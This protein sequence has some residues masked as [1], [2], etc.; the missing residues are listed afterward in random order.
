[1]A[2]GGGGQGRR[3]EARLRIH[4]P[5]R[6]GQAQAVALAV[7]A[8]CSAKRCAQ[9][10]SGSVFAS[11]VECKADGLVCELLRVTYYSRAEV[12]GVSSWGTAPAPRQ[13]R[14]GCRRRQA[15]DYEQNPKHRVSET[16]SMP[17]AGARACQGAAAELNVPR[18]HQHLRAGLGLGLGCARELE[19][20]ERL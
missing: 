4:R 19:V 6:L 2:S 7:Q 14:A 13:H 20:Q 12:T 3:V 10:L 17:G 5:R 9:T 18:L 16:D 11:R 1:M 8:Q 15:A